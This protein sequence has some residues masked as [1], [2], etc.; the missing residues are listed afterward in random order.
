MFENFL[1]KTKEQKFAD[2]ELV[3]DQILARQEAFRS[4]TDEQILTVSS[5]IK[6]R[7]R[8]ELK[9]LGQKPSKEERKEILDKYLV[10]SFALA[11]EVVKRECGFELHDVQVIG[12]IALHNGEVAQLAT[13]EGKTLMATMP[14]FL[15]GM[16]GDGTH[17]LAPNSYLAARD[18]ENNS[19]IFTRLGL[20]TGIIP[21]GRTRANLNEIKA[22]FACDVTYSSS[23]NL[24]FNFLHD[25]MAI[26]KE[27]M[28]NSMERYNFVVV[29]EVDSVLLDDARTPLI[30]SGISEADRARDINGVLASIQESFIEENARATRADD[31]IFKIYKLDKIKRKLYENNNA[32]KMQLL[33]DGLVHVLSSTAEYEMVVNNRFEKKESQNVMDTYAIIIDKST[34]NFQVTALG[35]RMISKYYIG[36]EVDKAFYEDLGKML[37]IR[38]SNGHPKYRNGEDFVIHQYG[39]Q[40]VLKLTDHGY[41]KVLRDRDNEKINAIYDGRKFAQE[42]VAD[43][44]SINNSIK[45]YWTLKQGVDYV[46]SDVKE[47]RDYVE[48]YANKKLTLIQGGRTAAD[49]TYAD[50]MQLAL[51]KK[52]QRLIDA[53]KSKEKGMNIRL[54]ES[55]STPELASIS[56]ST[57]FSLYSVLGGM[58]GTSAIESFDMM[59]GI[60]TTEL[61]KHVTYEAEKLRRMGKE[62]EVQY[63]NY[64]DKRYIKPSGM[65]TVKD[66]F[67]FTHTDKTGKEVSGDEAKFN[68]LIEELKIS[69]SKG[70]PVLISTTSVEES[71]KV[72]AKIREHLRFEV[73]LLNA[74]TKNEAEIISKAGRFGAITISTEM[75]GRGTDIKLG[76]ELDPN[77]RQEI[78]I[79]LAKRRFMAHAA[80]TG[81]DL[82]NQAVSTQAQKEFMARELAKLRAD[83]KA[84]WMHNH[85]EEKNRVMLAGGLKIVGVGHFMFDRVDRQV[86]GRSARQGDPGEA[87]FLSSEED[88]SKIGVYPSDY[89]RLVDRA[90]RNGENVL[91]GKEYEE[92]VRDKQAHNEMLAASHIKSS[93]KIEAIIQDIRLQFRGQQDQLK[94]T[95][96]YSQVVDYM[97]EKSVEQ[98]IIENAGKELSSKTKMAKSG[99]D[100]NRLR[101]EAKEYLDID[102]PEGVRAKATVKDL[103]IVMM[104]Q[105]Q[106]KHH[107][108]IVSKM[109]PEEYKNKYNVELMDMFSNTWTKFTD[110]VETEKNQEVL[111]SLVKYDQRSKIEY[112]IPAN[113]NQVVRE[114]RFDIASFI[115]TGRKTSYYEDRR[116]KE[117]VEQVE[118]EYDMTP[119][120]KTVKNI[121]AYSSASVLGFGARVNKGAP[122]G[123][124]LENDDIVSMKFK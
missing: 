81:I 76:G 64:N 59:Y 96:N 57:F 11:K 79:N 17:V 6:A 56:Q 52:E 23:A 41:E 35:E 112:R 2:M 95:E 124:V 89:K 36:S 78:F 104:R 98:M 69:I 37:E 54:I 108:N 119:S 115:L 70:Q 51:E 82:S 90:K 8:A 38:A 84:I 62:P 9:E 87:I 14:V 110:T 43:L 65:K 30:I 71:E 73:P 111:D 42:Y 113:Y 120:V 50:G 29:D 105:A 19:K 86:V 32:T 67:Y 20:S 91:R 101:R 12:G 5:N 28:A 122:Q 77:D 1:G 15:N 16:A 61:P 75:A 45:A 74:N 34:G 109:T 22:A 58:T 10:D 25:G 33:E 63:I 100:L 44:D 123:V 46:L 3:K 68:K 66:E 93:L 39:N 26:D 72:Q 121:Y 103:A 27:Q 60:D 80:E 83:A 24:I 114:S 118:D 88:L 53:S 49:R 107:Q 21:D 55:K 31:A 97:I 47:G 106:R 117:L 13:G 92:L 102:L 116:E 94:K 40:Q 18:A 4:L 85:E 7:I 48:G 99:I